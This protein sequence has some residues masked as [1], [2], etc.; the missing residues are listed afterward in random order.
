MKIAYFESRNFRAFRRLHLEGLRGVNLIAGQNNVG[1]T[2]LLEAL[3]QFSGSDQPDVGLRLDQFRG[4]QWIDEDHLFF[5]LFHGH[6]PSKT[7]EL[8]GRWNGN[9]NLHVLRIETRI[10]KTS[11]TPVRG[12]GSVGGAMPPISDNP[13]EIVLTYDNGSKKYESR[14]WFEPRVAGPGVVQKDFETLR[15]R[16]PDRPTGMYFSPSYR[17]PPQ[18]EADKLGRMQVKGGEDM[19][20]EALRLFEPRLHRL[21]T[22]SINGLPV[23]HADLG[24]EG[25]MPMGLLGDGMQRVLSLTLAFDTASGGMILIDEIENGIHHSK[26]K[27]LWSAIS[28]FAERFDVQ[29]FA[30]THSAECV[31]AAHE[32]FDRTDEYDFRFIR[33]DRVK[34]TAKAKSFDRTTLATA[35]K[36]SFEV[37]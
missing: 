22:V 28:S 14:G 10:R 7:I 36:A 3:W 15:E 17:N 4:I 8:L 16:I 13:R 19:V 1:K 20:V 35:I 37:R 24:R 6:D 30:T 29:V 21:V 23:I 12:N 26:L 18:E 34:G 25:L 27:D 5:D 33:L 32:S 11:R 31:R 2:A 9:P